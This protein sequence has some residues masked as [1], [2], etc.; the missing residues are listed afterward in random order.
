M[1]A[2]SGCSAKSRAR[3]IPRTFEDGRA[4]GPLRSEDHPEGLRGLTGGDLERV[5]KDNVACAWVLDQLQAVATSGR[6]A[7]RENPARS[8]HWCL[9]QEKDMVATAIWFD[10]MYS[11]CSFMGARCK[12]QRLRHNIL[13]IA[14]WPVVS[15]H[16][17]HDPKEWQPVL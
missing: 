7:L 3:E 8:L 1:A 16:H 10:T 6:G 11:S 5:T 14:D 9:K 12:Q 15:C 13:E 2:A 17:V 4:P